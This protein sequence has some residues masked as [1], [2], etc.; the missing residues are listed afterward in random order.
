MG[1]GRGPLPLLKTLLASWWNL[2][3]KD[4]KASEPQLPGHLEGLPR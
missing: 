3:G 1:Q 4:Y 2:T